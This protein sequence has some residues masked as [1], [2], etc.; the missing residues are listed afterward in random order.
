MPLWGKYDNAANSDIAA[1]IQY[2]QSAGNTTART[3]FFD[4]TTANTIVKSEKGA[5]NVVVGQFGVDTNEI[6][7]ANQAG[8]GHPQHAGWVVRHEGRGLKAGRVWYETMVAMGSITSDASDDAQF[9]DYTIV[10]S[11]Q[12][13]GNTMG[14][15]NVV[16]I[17]PVTATSVPSGATLTYQWQQNYTGSG[18]WVTVN[19][20]GGAVFSDNTA[21]T[22]HIA[23]NTT[24]T[25]NTF[26]VIVSSTSN[27]TGT[28]TSSNAVIT[29]L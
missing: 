29:V 19:Y 21:A 9:A 2:N 17:G 15:N 12:P 24:L 16:S 25:G 22:L 6:R 10:I 3:L 11:G 1:L 5:G 8:R 13:A 14:R 23:N 4:N 26:R 18:G 20:N 27:T 7:A 28:V